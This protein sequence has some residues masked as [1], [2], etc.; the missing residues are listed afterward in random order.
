M[1]IRTVDQVDSLIT[2]L[3]K[4]NTNM[5]DKI[6]LVRLMMVGKGISPA[7]SPL[8]QSKLWEIENM[9]RMIASNPDNVIPF[10]VG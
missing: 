10:E 4:V 1:R 8:V 3:H 9:L 7:E 2:D 5:A 6:Q